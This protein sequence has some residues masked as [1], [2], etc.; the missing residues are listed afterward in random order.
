MYLRLVFI[1]LWLI[2]SAR[3]GLRSHVV[4]C[5]A[6]GRVAWMAVNAWLWARLGRRRRFCWSGGVDG[7]GGLGWGD[8]VG[9]R[10]G[11]GQT[12][13]R[14]GRARPTSPLRGQGR[15]RRQSGEG[16]GAS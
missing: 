3:A 9:D 13:L 7:I 14:R 11:A 16:T 1:H 15:R 4:G 2:L 8:D 12:G 6:C 5:G 10:V